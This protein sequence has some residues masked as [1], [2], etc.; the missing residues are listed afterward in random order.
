VKPATDEGKPLRGEAVDWLLRLQ[1]SP[2]DA[3][4]RAGFYAWL[5]ASDAHRRAWQSVERVWRVS[6]ELPTAVG[7]SSVATVVEL[8][9]AGRVRRA[10]RAF[11]IAVAALAACVALYF[12]PVLK[13]RLQADHL[14]SVAELREVMLEDGS[15]VHLDAGSAIA[16]RYSPM[17]REVALLAG[18]AF[19]EVGASRERP[20]V[21]LVEDVSVTVTGTAFDVRSSSD[22]V[23][24]AVQSGTVEVG[25]RG[26]V[27]GTLTRGESLSVSLGSRQVVKSK[28]APDDVA[29]WRERRLVVDGATL[30]EVVDELGRHHPGIIVLRDRSLAERR[31]TGVFDLRRPVEALNAIAR[32]QHGAITEITPYVLVVSA[33]SRS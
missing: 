17:R 4:V 13:L 32:S 18:R 2:D 19:F 7:S 20:F 11:G 10:G 6:G 12:A 24:V 15:I 33:G 16:I 27:A 26:R 31:I 5:A 28:V 9:R 8:P 3:A 14:T 25:E 21:V 29:S 22:A 23:T 1:A 30:A